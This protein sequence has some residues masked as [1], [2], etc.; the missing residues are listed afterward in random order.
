MTKKQIDVFDKIITSVNWKLGNFNMLPIFFGTVM[1]LI[2]ICMM[3]TIK[4]VS[5]GSIPSSWGLPLSIGLYAL[6]PLVFLK[7]MKHDGMVA[8]NLIWN[9]MSNV[10]VTLQGIFVFG[11]SIKGLRWVGICM[12]I[13]SLFL[14]AYTDE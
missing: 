7:A 12:S 6:E 3:S 5:K 13:L 10:I 11:E 4:M 14:L 2:D 8:T 1:A 9:L